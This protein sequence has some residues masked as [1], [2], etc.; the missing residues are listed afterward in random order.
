MQV[1]ML[2][3]KN[4]LSSLVA[5]AEKGEPVILARNGVAVARIVKYEP[6]RVQPP[7]LWKGRCEFAPDW[8]SPETNQEVEKLL[9]A[10]D[11][12]AA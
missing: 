8:D 3:A 6:P 2:D 5:A 12:S 9:L 11:A 1:N 7:G 10:D 4:R